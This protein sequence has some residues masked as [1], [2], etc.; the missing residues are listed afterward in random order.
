[1]G[2]RN[3][4]CID[5]KKN[6]DD[7]YE[8]DS[9]GSILC[10][11][12]RKDFT[13]GPGSS[14]GYCKDCSLCPICGEEHN[15]HEDFHCE[16][17]V[18]GCENCGEFCNICGEGF[19]VNCI[20]NHHCEEDDSIGLEDAQVTV[21]CPFCGEEIVRAYDH[22]L[23]PDGLADKEK[24]EITCI[25]YDTSGGIC[26]HLAFLSDWAYAGSEFIP[27]LQRKMENIAAAI[28]GDEESIGP[29][30]I[31]NERQYGEDLHIYATESLPD[32][33]F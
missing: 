5:C 17:G 26:E 22:S 28:S 11:D 31:E 30:I 7:I 15:M 1:M 2:E 27:K 18:K 25:T 16:C 24:E 6:V 33:N 13:T 3:N 9:C 4:V 29:R 14:Y 20:K 10:E 19:C 12:C 32:L 23:L 8:C 21:S